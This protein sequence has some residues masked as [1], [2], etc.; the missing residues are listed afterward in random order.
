M[1]QRIY[2]GQSYAL[3][4]TIPHRRRDGTETTLSRWRSNCAT[5]GAEFTFTSPT[6]RAKF[7]PNRRCEQ[8]RQPG[9][10]AGGDE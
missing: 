10:C 3:V 9:V 7:E 2:K 8:H 5:C 6:H 4:E 1:T